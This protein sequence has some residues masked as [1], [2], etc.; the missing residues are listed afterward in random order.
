MKVLF[1]I[2]NFKTMMFFL[3]LGIS[4][5]LY[6]YLVSTRPEAKPS[7]VEEKTFYVNVINPKRNNYSPISDAYGKI[8]SS[9]SGDLRFGV[10]GRVNFISDKLLNGSFVTKGEILAKLD[11]RRF[12]LEIEKLTSET[13][14]LAE[15]LSIRERQVNRYKTMLKNNVVSQNKYDNE[16]ILL[17]KNRS[18]YIRAKTMLERAKEDLSDTVL[19]SHFNGRLFNVKIN[20]GQFVKSNEKIANIFST[21]NLEVEF[22]VP[23]KIYSNSKDLIGKSID[24]LWK[25]GTTSLKT[26]K[27]IIERSDGKTNEEEGGGKLFAK[28]DKFEKRENYIPL[29]TFVRVDYPVGDFKNVFKLPESSLFTDK[30]YIVENGIAKQ[31]KIKLIYKGSGYILVDG[32]LSENDYIITTRIPDNLNNQKI[33]I[34]N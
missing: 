18:D 16:L 7:T 23:S 17:S 33:K 6:K 30:V 20:Q 1:K 21:E 12:L 14:E 34:L 22:V 15:Q 13:K 28:I 3:V 4:I 32:N 8:I 31:K 25:G 9:R 27:G 11:Q 26:M 29:G 19:K 10:S 24:V 5:F 2:F